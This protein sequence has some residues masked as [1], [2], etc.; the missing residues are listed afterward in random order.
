MIT[1]FIVS[2]PA[3]DDFGEI[4]QDHIFSYLLK[5]KAESLPAR[6]LKWKGMSASRIATE[7]MYWDKLTEDT[8]SA[9][10]LG[11][12]RPMK[13]IYMELRSQRDFPWL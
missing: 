1:D 12:T 2:L 8:R 7:A 5:I 13:Q 11:D 6:I 4:E 3:A 10:A 9:M